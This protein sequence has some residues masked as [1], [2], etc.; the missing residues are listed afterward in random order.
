MGVQ[1][2]E[3]SRGKVGMRK[4]L[5]CSLPALPTLQIISVGIG[6][7]VKRVPTVVSCAGLLQC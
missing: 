4:S 7:A 2:F 3:L 6:F 5:T 1:Q